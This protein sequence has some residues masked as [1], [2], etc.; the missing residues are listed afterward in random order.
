MKLQ[1]SEIGRTSLIE[2]PYWNKYTMTIREAAEY[3]HHGAK[4]LYQFVK[5]SESDAK[6]LM[7]NGNRIM[8]SGRLHLQRYPYLTV[9][10][11]K[12]VEEIDM[13]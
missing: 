6:Y 11:E 7:R 9:K 5:S 1:K 12:N 10:T 13:A 2:I 8:T 4:K 3:F